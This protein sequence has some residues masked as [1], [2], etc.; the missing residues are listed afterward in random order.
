MIDHTA[1]F[2]HLR[3]TPLKAWENEFYTAITDALRPGIHGDVDKWNAILK[4]LPEFNASQIVLDKGQVTAGYEQDLQGMSQRE[5]TQLLK[6]LKPWRK[7]PF[8]LAGVLIDTEWRSDWKWQRVLPHI[9]SLEGRT[10]LDIGCGSG[11]HLWRM[12]GE[13]AAMTIGIDPS[14][15]FMMQ[16]YAVQH[17]M[18]QHPVYYLPVGIEKMPPAMRVFDTVFSMGV[19]YHR[20]SPMDHLFELRGLLKPGG[21]LVLETL[22][23]DGGI[24]DVLVPSGRYA[25]MGNVWFL[26]SAD[27]M[28]LWL[29]K[30]GFKNVRVVDT[31]VTTIEEQR[32]TE[33]M[34][35][36]SLKDFL[37][38]NDHGKTIEGYPAPLRAVFVAEAP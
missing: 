17:F 21:E 3:Q 15:L 32:V 14:L 19:L 34:T 16:F 2:E 24:G 36:H 26:P 38:P 37:D 8:S 25:R 1:F 4:A 33:W 12:R 28:V 22:I 6:Q 31:A 11:Y 35:F 9:S 10:I 18:G 30:C 7:G 23:I 5:L 29:T 27:A 13:G 20:R